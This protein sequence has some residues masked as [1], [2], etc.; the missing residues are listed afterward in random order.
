[1][2]PKYS[3]YSG[4]AIKDA[5]ATAGAPRYKSEFQEGEP[6]VEFFTQLPKHS[7]AVFSTVFDTRP[8]RLIENPTRER[9][10]YYWWAAEIQRVCDEL[11]RNLPDVCRTIETPQSYWDLYKYF[12]AYDIYYR[13][14]QNLW[15]VINTLIFENEYAQ[16]IVENEQ[17]ME[18]ERFM[19]LFEHL[20][21]ELLR[22]PGMQ[23]KLLT[24]DRNRQQDVLKVLTAYELQIFEGYEKY[25]D[26]FLGAI[27]AIFVGC[28]E[29]L[30]KGTGPLA[31]CLAPVV[32]S[33]ELGKCA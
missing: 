2:A 16:R 22:R 17:K 31:S 10:G 3:L 4:F 23:N 12:D 32:A 28:Y 24:W 30:R 8:F 21:S 25:P 9:K 11:R 27:R 14:A 20:A 1:M 13:G 7:T 6:P 19:P 26:H 33:K 18:I 15:N 29:N 5:L